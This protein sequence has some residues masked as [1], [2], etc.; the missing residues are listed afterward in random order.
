MQAEERQTTLP[1]HP[2]TVLWKGSLHR[3][4]LPVTPQPSLLELQE[5]VE[6]VCGWKELP[7][8]ALKDPFSGDV[9]YLETDNDLT[10]AVALYKS[11][12]AE[13][14]LK[15]VVL[16][17]PISSA[18]PFQMAVKIYKHRGKRKEEIHLRHLHVH[19]LKDLQAT[20]KQEFYPEEAQEEKQVETEEEKAK[21]E[22]ASF[23]LNWID[24]RGDEI[25]LEND[26]QLHYILRCHRE[27]GWPYL[28]IV[29]P[30]YKKTRRHTLQT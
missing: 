19:S 8:L 3:I 16:N 24:N 29:L 4:D 6:K 14:P 17:E 26:P 20:L 25:E 22:A 7:L 15:L 18:E 5:A 23:R 28:K 30:N 27:E 10:T 2:F 21:E 9:I 1:Q 11:L 13:R 12:H